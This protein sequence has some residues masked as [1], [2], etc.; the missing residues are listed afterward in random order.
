MV[1]A[2]MRRALLGLILIGP[3]FGYA[4]DAA[5]RAAPLRPGVPPPVVA[6]APLPGRKIGGVDCVRISDLASRL[7]LQVSVRDRGKRV[8][9]TGPVGRTELERDAREATIDGLRVFLGD[10]VLEAGG[11]L[12]VSR[13]DAE[14]CLTPLLRPGLGVN[15]PTAPRIV[16][17]DPGHGGKDNGTSA[18]EKTYALDVARRAKK[19]LEDSGVRVVLTRDSD[20]FLDLPQR[21]AIANANRADLFV[22]IHFN[23]LPRDTKTSG[24]EVF[25]FAPQFQRSTNSWSPREGDDTER[26]AAPVNR[27]DHWSAVLAHAVHRRFVVDL[28]TFDRGK[29]LAHWGV[30]RALSCP[31]VLIECGFLTSESESRKIGTA[32]YR[33]KLA[34]ALAAGVRDYGLA[35]EGPTRRPTFAPPDTRTP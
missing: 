29:K 18:H 3:V 30:L 11:H 12:Y 20:V 1:P 10:P 17:L 6:L 33:Q 21:A 22:S 8:S 34:E 35:I 19:L 23:A 5:A 24:V 31:G 28:K 4:A 16:V 32:A 14:R 9:F 13:I 26:E 15:V 25:T 27:H 7:G 2:A